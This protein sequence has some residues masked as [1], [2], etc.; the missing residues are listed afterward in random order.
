[1]KFTLRL[2]VGYFLIVGLTGWFVLTIF[3]DEVKPSVRE[4]LEHNMVDTAH[5]LAELAAP[6]L[7]QNQITPNAR[8]RF[9]EALERYRQRDIKA[10]IWGLKKQS[11]DLG[12]YLTDA[13]GV[14]R[15]ATEPKLIGQDYSRW[16]DV[17]K[18]LRGEYGARSTRDNPDDDHSSV[19]HVAAPVYHDGKIIGVLTVSKAIASVDP[20]IARAERKIGRYGIMLLGLSLLIGVAF[21]AWITWRINRLRRYAQAV[22]RGERVSLPPVG[23]TELADLGQALESM[24]TQLDGKQ[25][26]EQYVQ[27]LTHEL[28]SPLTAIRAAAECLDWAQSE[29]ERQGFTQ[30]ILAQTERMQRGIDAQLNL[31]HLEQMRGLENP[32]TTDVLVLLE[33]ILHDYQPLADAKSVEWDWQTELTS[34]PVLADAPRLQQALSA[35]LSNALAFSP[36]HAAIQIR[37]QTQLNQLSLTIR[38]HGPGIPDFAL[39]RIFERYYSLPRPKQRRADGSEQAGEKSTG[40][41]LA[42]AQEI[43]QLHHGQLRVENAV[44]GGTLVTLTL[45]LHINS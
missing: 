7:A 20:I 36:S 4:A 12:I 32:Q 28:K 17:L 11:L 8:T 27:A 38:D 6:E 41:G 23:R 35:L 22:A 30:T 43:T 39:P 37:L 21:T 10:N 26:I 14:V 24:R 42:I 9:T 29:T 33:T 13:Q 3:I 18:T 15:Y 2:L 1:M 40:L 19:F 34:A 45:P 44:G 25:Y 31:A 5:A 16:N